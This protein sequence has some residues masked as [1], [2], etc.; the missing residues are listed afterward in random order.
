MFPLAPALSLA[1]MPTILS[2]T[3]VL[4][5][6]KVGS[7]PSLTIWIEKFPRASVVPT[8]RIFAVIGAFRPVRQ[9]RRVDQR[10]RDGIAEVG[11]LA[12]A[13]DD[14]RGVIGDVGQVEPPPLSV[15][16]SSLVS[17]GEDVGCQPDGEEP[18]NAPVVAIKTSGSPG[19]WVA[20]PVV[21][22]TAPRLIWRLVTST[23]GR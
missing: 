15:D 22:L 8:P 13:V 6:K 12:D 2:S 3:L 16:G 1:W 4:L 5:A 9:P 18:L 23:L 11:N 21:G 20:W 14:G 7:P 17:G 10:D 19:V